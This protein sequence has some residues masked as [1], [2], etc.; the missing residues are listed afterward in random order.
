M[1]TTPT[2]APVLTLDQATAAVTAAEKTY[3]T[4]SAS[5]A[6]LVTKLQADISAYMAALQALQA[7]VAA[8]ITTLQ[9]TVIA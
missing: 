5:H 4:D 2:P 9:G 1:S 3:A 8:E 6:T 7:I